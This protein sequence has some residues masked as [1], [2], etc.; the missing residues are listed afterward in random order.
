[1]GAAQNL[2]P[3][4][5]VSLSEGQTSTWIRWFTI[6]QQLI[7]QW[8]F[9]RSSVAVTPVTGFTIAASTSAATLLLIPAGVLATGTVTLPASAKEGDEFFLLTTATVTALT[10]LPA[11]GQNVVGAGTGTLTAGVR[12]GFK[13]LGPATWYR[14][15]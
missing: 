7:Q 10:V 4:P 8:G 15:Q 13:F 2:P 9:A 6:L 11:S 5:A 14:M 1:M 3:V 12:W